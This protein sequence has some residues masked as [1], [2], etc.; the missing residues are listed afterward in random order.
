LAAPPEFCADENTVTRSVR[1]LLTRP[2]YIL[3]TPAELY[4]SRE[5]ALGARDE[6]WP[7]KVGRH[8]WTVL[9]RDLKI[10]ERP[11]ELAAY[12]ASRL[13]VFLLPGQATAS[14]L[15]GLAEINLA[16]IC[17]IARRG[18]RERGASH[19]AGHNHLRSPRNRYE[20]AV[21]DPR[22]ATASC[23]TVTHGKGLLESQ[24]PAD[25]ERLLVR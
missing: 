13:Q 2:G 11:S 8:H 5:A 25:Y 24:R 23:S 6:D 15:V 10:Y 12:Q 21:A 17:A 14:G 16:Q 20:A 3:H 18:S 19:T 1:N 9:G 4:G 22:G 7:A